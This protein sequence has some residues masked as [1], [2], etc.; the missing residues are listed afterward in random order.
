MRPGN[1]IPV[2]FAAGLALL[3]AAAP[4]G[5]ADPAASR[6]DFAALAGRW[7]V[8]GVAVGPGVQ[9]LVADD[10]AYMG[11]TLAIG[12]GLLAWED[13]AAGHATTGDRCED[14]VTA[15]QSGPAA[16]AYRQRFAAQLARFGL[17]HPDPHAIECD[18]GQWGPEAAGG[19][20]LFPA[21]RG[22]L[23]MSWYDG[24]LL[25]LDRAPAGRR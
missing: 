25:L 11:R 7:Q 5:A 23:A 22:R 4:L 13:G 18:R 19:A 12:P 16:A 14:P 20:I 17:R 2:I 8:V 3:G 15:R 1:R 9:A 10:P 21:P 6:I 24:A